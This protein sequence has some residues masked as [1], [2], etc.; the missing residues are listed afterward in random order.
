MSK[1]NVFVITYGSRI[2]GVFTDEK[3]AR[4]I[5]DNFEDIYSEYADEIEDEDPT[6]KFNVSMIEVPIN[7]IC[8]GQCQSQDEIDEALES[9]VKKGLI[10]PLIGEDGE[11]Y[12]RQVK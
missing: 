9:L 12:F 8:V 7:T 10:E 11:F 1:E 3:K 4:E 2:F 5:Y 6:E